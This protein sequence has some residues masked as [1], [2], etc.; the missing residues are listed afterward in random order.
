M[1]VDRN[2]IL[3][4]AVN[5]GKS[6]LT[7]FIIGQEEVRS[8]GGREVTILSQ[9]KPSSILR[10]FETTPENRKDVCLE[11]VRNQTVDTCFVVV[12][13]VT[14]SDEFVNE[15]VR[16]KELS[17]QLAEWSYSL[18]GNCFVVFTHIDELVD[19]VDKQ[20]FVDREFG[21][22]LCLVDRRC[23]FIN[24]TLRTQENRNRL[25]DE[26]IHL[27]KPV[28]KILCYGDIQFPGEMIQQIIEIPDN[29]SLLEE[30]GLRLYFHPDLSKGDKYREFV[31][32]PQ[33]SSI[34]GL[35]DEV[36][37][38]VTVIV[39][40]VTLTEAYCKDY[41]ILIN[42]LPSTHGLDVNSE[43]YF[44]DRVV[45]LFRIIGGDFKE[46]FEHTI[47]N[48]PAVMALMIR[49]GW[50]YT[51]ISPIVRDNE[52]L[53][54]F[55][56]LCQQVKRENNFRQF[57]GGKNIIERATRDIS[58]RKK[59]SSIVSLWISKDALQT[60]MKAKELQVENRSIR[61]YHSTANGLVEAHSKILKM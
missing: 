29:S 52:F 59:E 53:Q 11:I 2:L 15:L 57:I 28:L 40:L 20:Q 42:R 51:H 56:P 31:L 37:R 23:V 22:I 16:L 58:L 17:E 3:I 44:W 41:E 12:I 39:I 6:V 61:A 5:C 46:I 25:L 43:K 19:G 4:G 33:V 13:D 21:D 54:K 50:R 36:G 55:I 45:V 7:D 18:F 32:E 24:S 48:N 1:Q 47:H 34:I 49:T 10:I 60:V 38:G 8:I 27:S 9:G 14:K 30:L 35:P 26:L